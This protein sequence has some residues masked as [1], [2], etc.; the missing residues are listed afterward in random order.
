MEKLTLALLGSG[1]VLVFAVLFALPTQLLWNWALVPAIDG[2]N[3][4]GF[5]QALGINMLATILF[6]GADVKSN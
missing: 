1:L 6:K 3:T 2:V 4:I 5:W